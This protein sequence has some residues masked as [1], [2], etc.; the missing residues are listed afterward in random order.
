M[1]KDKAPMCCKKPMELK[2]IQEI[3][4]ETQSN[5]TFAWFQ[6][7]KCGKYGIIEK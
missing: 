4:F 3:L 1:I 5:S 6:C 2:A 7:K